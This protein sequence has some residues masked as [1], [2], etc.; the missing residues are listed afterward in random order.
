MSQHGTPSPGTD[1]NSSLCI[2]RDEHALCLW[3]VLA[4]EHRTMNKKKKVLLVS[5]REYRQ[6]F[7]L[8]YLSVRL[9][10][11]IFMSSILL[12]QIEDADTSLYCK[13]VI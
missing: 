12:I 10:L 2:P 9:C 1:P 11:G 4:V 8:Q 6:F 7:F 5:L 3:Q 13:E